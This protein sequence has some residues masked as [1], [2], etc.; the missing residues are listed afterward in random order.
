MR[1]PVKSVT[2]VVVEPHGAQ[3]RG[4]GKP[5][6]HRHIRHVEQDLQQIAE[7]QRQAEKKDLLCKGSLS[8]IPL[9]YIHQKFPVLSLLVISAPQC[10]TAAARSQE[11]FS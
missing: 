10:T 5:A 7:N 3:G 4:S 2:S 9:L 1:K 6:H 11:T 8:Q